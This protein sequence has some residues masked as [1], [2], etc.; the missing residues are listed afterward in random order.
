MV[1]GSFCLL[2]NN[3]INSSL[4]D[5]IKMKGF[6]VVFDTPIAFLDASVRTECTAWIFWVGEREKRENDEIS[7]V[8]PYGMVRP[9]RYHR[10]VRATNLC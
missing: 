3:E 10:G 7:M 2:A 8:P 1:V 6:V 4:M 5:K 9:E